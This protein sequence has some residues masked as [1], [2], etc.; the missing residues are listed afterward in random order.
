MVT[1]PAGWFR[2]GCDP[3]QGCEV[4]T[5]GPMALI[6]DELVP[7]FELDRREVSVG[8]YRACW[9]AGFCEAAN[10]H[11][12][13]LA[14]ERRGSAPRS[15]ADPGKPPNPIFENADPRLPMW[16]VTGFEAR[17]YCTWVRKRLP[18]ALE[19]EKAARGTDARPYPWGHEPPT[20]ERTSNMHWNREPPGF[21]LPVGSQP[22]G[23]SPYGVLD[24]GGSVMEYVDPDDVGDTDERER[25]FI[26]GSSPQAVL[27]PS[28]LVL[29]QIY[30][31]KGLYRRNPDPV[32]GFRCARWPLSPR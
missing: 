31:A 14:A 27:V 16:D 8:E 5:S 21:P 18:T 12:I 29:P 23:A 3:S 25:I 20:R 13:A 7:A 10:Q 11:V 24:L 26:A 6:H 28:N 17:A 22:A 19:W 30:R 4:A 2:S 15:L 9:S 1:V 32:A